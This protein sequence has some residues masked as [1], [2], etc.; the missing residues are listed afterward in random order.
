ML[1]YYRNDFGGVSSRIKQGRLVG[2]G[3]GM[4]SGDQTSA[5]VGGSYGIMLALLELP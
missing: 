5:R 1:K 4:C 3:L 2:H